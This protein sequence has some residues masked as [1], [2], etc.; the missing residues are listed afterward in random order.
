MSNHPVIL[1]TPL[2]GSLRAE[3]RRDSHDLEWLDQALENVPERLDVADASRLL[4]LSPAMIRALVETG[5][6]EG[7]RDGGKLLVTRASIRKYVAAGRDEVR[8]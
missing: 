1:G 8:S 7:E 5:R 4:S 6:L 2:S 3:A